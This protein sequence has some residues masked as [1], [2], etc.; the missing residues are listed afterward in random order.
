MAVAGRCDRDSSSHR[1][2]SAHRPAGMRRLSGSSTGPVD[3]EHQSPVRDERARAGPD[4]GYR[5][6]GERRW[7]QEQ[8]IAEQRAQEAAARELA[9][10]AAR[11]A[12]EAEAASRRVEEEEAAAAASRPAAAL[13]GSCAPLRAA[14]PSRP[15][16][17]L[18]AGLER[19]ER[20]IAMLPRER[21][22]E[23]IEAMSACLRRRLLGRLEACLGGRAPTLFEATSAL[24]SLV[25]LP[26]SLSFQAACAEMVAKLRSSLAAQ[27]RSF[28]E[29]LLPLL[30]ALLMVRRLRRRSIASN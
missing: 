10:E 11:E 9:E 20:A 23:V 28:L 5:G 16:Q 7:H 14:P 29:V 27:P 25:Q 17:S 4:G 3:A 12:A 19:L 1:S 22:C 6:S 26:F 18:S 30:V 13:P 21:R 15:Q 2:G 24:A 8:A